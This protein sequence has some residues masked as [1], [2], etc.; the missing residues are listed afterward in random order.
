M[1]MYEVTVSYR[2][3]VSVLVDGEN[4]DDACDNVTDG[5]RE[6]LHNGGLDVCRVEEMDRLVEEV[7]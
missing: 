4:E 5:L 3:R 6:A 7:E 2:V 1:P